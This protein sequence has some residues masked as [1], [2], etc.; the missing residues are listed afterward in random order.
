[1]TLVPLTTV[2]VMAVRVPSAAR[3]NPSIRPGPR[4]AVQ[5]KYSPCIYRKHTNPQGQGVDRS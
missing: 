1:M 2:S 3:L 5:Y 4:L